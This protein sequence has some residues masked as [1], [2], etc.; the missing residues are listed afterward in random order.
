MADSGI[1]EYQGKQI[2][3]L[4]EKLLDAT[5]RLEREVAEINKEAYKIR[6]NTSN[7]VTKS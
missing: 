4:L 3:A 5:N 2:I 6:C 1:T 7:L